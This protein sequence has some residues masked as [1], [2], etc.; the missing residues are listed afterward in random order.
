MT[1]RKIGKHP[2]L[3]APYGG[4]VT[5]RISGKLLGHSQPPKKG[6]TLNGWD[7]SAL[8]AARKDYDAI[9]LA[10]LENPFSVAGLRSSWYL[11]HAETLLQIAEIS[12]V[13]I[14]KTDKP[15]D[16]VHK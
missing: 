2:A 1:K 9:E 10:A 12:T 4:C 11:D 13:G 14:S 7:K 15:Q 3:A 16:N 5:G 8:E 6:K